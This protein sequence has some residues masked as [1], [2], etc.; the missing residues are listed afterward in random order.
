MN[1]SCIVELPKPPKFCSGE[2][3]ENEFIINRTLDFIK[4]YNFI[5]N[6]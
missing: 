5:I 1:C 3:F 2:F 4:N 6:N